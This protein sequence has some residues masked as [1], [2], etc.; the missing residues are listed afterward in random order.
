MELFRYQSLTGRGYDVVKT[1]LL[2]SKFIVRSAAFF[3]DPFDSIFREIISW[4][5]IDVLAFLSRQKKA[6]RNISPDDE[7]KIRKAVRDKNHKLFLSMIRGFSEEAR[8]G[9]KVLCFCEQWDG[10]PMWAHY[11]DN[12]QGVC[13]GF[14]DLPN[15]LKVQY[16]LELPA[17]NVISSDGEKL[18]NALSCKAK[19]WE[20]EREWRIIISDPKSEVIERVYPHESLS[21]VILGSK[22]SS[23]NKRA[24]LSWCSARPHRPKIY[25]AKPKSREFGLE[26]EEILLSA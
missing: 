19:D 16:V 20:Y 4:N 14:Q 10:L 21:K 12:H 3:N 15:A 17:Y 11:A 9:L 24:I 13:L 22:I 26:L 8:E 1:I 25:Q 6:G 5:L 7:R 23:D 18:V 2:E